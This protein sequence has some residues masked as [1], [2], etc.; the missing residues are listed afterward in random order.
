[1][2]DYTVTTTELAEVTLDSSF[3]I[4]TT[5]KGDIEI[6][7]KRML[8]EPIYSENAYFNATKIA[9]MYGKA[10]NDVIRGDIWKDYVKYTEEELTFK[11]ENNAYLKVPKLVKTVRGKYHSGT[12]LHNELIV[13]FIRRLDVRLA[14]KMDFF[15]KDLIRHSN[16]IK[17]ERSEVKVLFHQLTDTIKDIYIPAQESE[18]S[19]KFAYSA[20]S[21][22]VN[23]MVLGTTA[24]KYALDNDIAIEKGKS[25]RDY[26]SK[27]QIAYIKYKE[28]ELN[29]YIRY[30]GI[31]DYQELKEKLSPMKG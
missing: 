25:I 13:E 24:K 1:M 27:Q 16:A 20:L 15:I 22:M 9:K 10:T 12:W 31:T 21:T 7:V 14:V 2:E 28:E 18:N 6:D 3:L 19:K 5:P 8:K 17:I 30:G 29:G 23:M 11:Y 26:L 4:L